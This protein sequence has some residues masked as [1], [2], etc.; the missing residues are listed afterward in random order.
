MQLLKYYYSTQNIIC[1]QCLFQHVQMND[2]E[3]YA[4]LIQLKLALQ[5]N[6]ENKFLKYQFS[7]DN[8]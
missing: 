4:C 2:L 7:N 6:T 3:L 5:T 1:I 8:I